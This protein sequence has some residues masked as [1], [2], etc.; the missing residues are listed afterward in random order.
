MGSA[1]SAV[2]IIGPFLTPAIPILE[3]VGLAGPSA[4]AVDVGTLTSPQIAALANLEE[5]LS[6]IVYNLNITSTPTN[7]ESTVTSAA[8]TPQSTGSSNDSSLGTDGGTLETRG[9]LDL[10]SIL[11]GLPI[12]GPFLKPLLPLLDSIGLGA[13]SIASVDDIKTVS[14]EQATTLAKLEFM[15]AE[16]VNGFKAKSDSPDATS[17]V[18]PAQATSST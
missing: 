10:G 12:I 14:V 6:T 2:P 3:S 7:A 17:S 15:L 8:A 13:S 18:S 1:L 5:V 4:A 9:L 16:A 11:A